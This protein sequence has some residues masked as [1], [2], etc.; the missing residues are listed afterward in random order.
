MGPYGSLC[1]GW[2]P[3]SLDGSPWINMVP[4]VAFVSY[5]YA[6]LHMVWIDPR[7]VQMGQDGFLW[8]PIAFYGLN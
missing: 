6:W 4:I 7:K 3:R 2:L 1:V 5:R 8:V